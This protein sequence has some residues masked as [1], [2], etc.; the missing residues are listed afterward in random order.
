MHWHFLFFC[1]FCFR[2]DGRVFAALRSFVRALL[3]ALIPCF[4]F[5]LLFFPPAVFQR[6]V[7]EPGSHDS[8]TVTTCGRDGLHS[9]CGAYW[10]QE[11]RDDT[12]CACASVYFSR[13]CTSSPEI[14]FGAAAFVSKDIPAHRSWTLTYGIAGGEARLAGGIN[15]KAHGDAVPQ[16][17][18]RCVLTWS[19]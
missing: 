14:P 6:M 5:L 17:Q 13:L 15:R 11:Q 9:I 7:F 10:C 16:M 4:I 1:P 12:S 2:T 8:L 19:P 3:P 18:K